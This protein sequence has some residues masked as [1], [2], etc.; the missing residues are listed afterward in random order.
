[1]LFFGSGDAGRAIS[2]FNLALSYFPGYPAAIEN[3]GLV[4]AF[5]GQPDSGRIYLNRYLQLEP[6]SPE[7]PKVRQVLSRLGS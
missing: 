5:S 4:F 7:V 6:D 3:K 1:M 2:D